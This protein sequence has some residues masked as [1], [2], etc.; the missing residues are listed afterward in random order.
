[1]SGNPTAPTTDTADGHLWITGPSSAGRSAT[2]R[3][4]TGAG[5]IVID[6]H[7][8]RRGPYTA[9][10]SLLR[11]VAADAIASCPDLVAEHDTEILTVAPELRSRITASRESLTTAAAPEE[12]TRFYPGAHAQRVAHGL[13]EFLAAYARER[14]PAGWTVVVDHADQ[15]DVTDA[16][17]LA[18]LV[19]RVP[20]AVLRVI[21]CGSESILADPDHAAMCTQH[22]SEVTVPGIS[23]DDDGIDLVVDAQSYVHSDGT[24]DDPRLHAAY[25]A[26]DREQRAALHDRRA[27]E[28]E[29]G[30]ESWLMGAVP[31]HRE[32]GSDPAGAGVAAL[33][34]AIERCVLLGFYDAVL[35]F[36][37]RCHA[38][39]DWADDPRRCW[40]VTA[41][42]CT[43]LTAMGR[44]EEAADEYD[45][46][47]AATT[48]PSVHLQAAYGRAMLFTRFY[49]ADKRDH[50]LAKSWINTAI[51]ISSLLPDEEQR[52][53]NVTF[54]ENGLALIEMHL[55]D[56]RQAL[57]LVTDGL[58]RL[59]REF[60]PDHQTLHQSVLLYNR[61]Q[62]LAALGPQ[63]EALAEYGRLIAADPHHS[64]YRFER[65][66]I[67]RKLGDVDAALEDYAQAMRLS[68]PYL[69]P[70]YNRADLLLEI[71]DVAAA[72]ADLDYVLELDPTYLDAYVNRAGAHEALGDLEAAAADVAAGLALSPD[73][74]HLLCLQ[75]VIAAD[76]GDGVTARACFDRALQVDP[77]ST[78]ALSNRAVLS[79]QEADLDAAIADLTA[80]LEITRDPALLANRALAYRDAGRLAEAAADYADA[81]QLDPEDD[82]AAG[83]LAKLMAAA[84]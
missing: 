9:A 83:E 1:M 20:P 81:V 59:E 26:L 79:Y 37:R 57:Q 69:E 73:Q 13:V 65:A 53:F 21:L 52:A 41:K 42:V 43:A 2:A 82:E 40:L 78:A 35:D 39:L 10:G 49:E 15:A 23:P 8:G 36:G 27:T 48:D 63:S 32:H 74:P 56:L 50:R 38:L 17:F 33:F 71:G 61:A 76:Q 44:P 47:C 11:A 72:I 4:L 3:R 54:N 77:R 7:R 16:Q 68:P 84:G 29:L 14:H 18:T 55:G 24:T 51:S 70:W 58:A 22:T 28:L 34:T 31:Y 19:R 66:A 25:L 75:G 64:E 30:D 6:G 12:R 60:G 80:A 46:A 45:R 5:G 67:H 62:L